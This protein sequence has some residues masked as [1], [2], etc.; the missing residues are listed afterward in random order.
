MWVYQ[1]YGIFHKG[2]IVLTKSAFLFNFCK[3]TIDNFPYKKYN[4]LVM[5]LGI[6][7]EFQKSLKGECIYYEKTD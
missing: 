7:K 3:K 2:S 1:R 5:Q 6:S 4:G